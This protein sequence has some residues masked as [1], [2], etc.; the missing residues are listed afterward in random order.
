[1]ST[2]AL[3]WIV[4]ATIGFTSRMHNVGKP[5]KPLTIGQVLFAQGLSVGL[6]YW[7]GFFSAGCAS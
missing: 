6:L 7:G 4:L 5:N 3:I 1:M 2:P